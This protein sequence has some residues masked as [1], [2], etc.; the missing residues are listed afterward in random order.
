MDERVAS[1]LIEALK[2]ALAEPGE[3]RLYKSGKLDGLF[4]GRTGANAEA[5]QYALRDNL[6]EIVRTETK[7]KTTT[8]WVR[9]TPKAIDFLHA[10]ES[11]V[12]ALKDLQSVLQVTREGI[13]LWL[14]EMRQQLQSLG[15][16][17][18]EEAER[19][20]HRLNALSEQVEEAL[21]RVEL[22]EPVV[23][24]AV[25]EDVPWAADALAYLD[26][27]R[28]TGTPG[29]CPLPELFAS[30]QG[31]HTDLTVPAFHERLRRLNDRGVLR[32]VPFSGPATELAEPEWAMVDGA[33]LLY[34]VAR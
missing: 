28:A 20:T 1:L 15:T 11:P 23:P 27:R 30:L 14:A 19:W 21:R 4:A 16:R 33:S 29:D 24:S 25:K 32:L 13:P 12:R 10:H 26:R 17:L 8:E 6:L 2:Q 31:K 34:Y 5:A 7:G 9:A 3:Q 18:A 22:A